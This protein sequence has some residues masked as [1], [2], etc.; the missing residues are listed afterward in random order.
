MHPVVIIWVC[1]YRPSAN[2]ESASDVLSLIARFNLI[3]QNDIVS[4]NVR[5]PR[6]R[7]QE[8][9][10]IVDYTNTTHSGTLSYFVIGGKWVTWYAAQNT[11]LCD[12]HVDQLMSCLAAILVQYYS[13]RCHI[14]DV[15]LKLTKKKQTLTICIA[16]FSWILLI[17][18]KSISINWLLVLKLNIF[19]AQCT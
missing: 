14:R 4:S 17:I 12:A 15:F 7:Q 8:L 1:I 6:S 16:T 11:C 3:R 2:N 18:V 9:L 5:F 13:F 10:K 19:R